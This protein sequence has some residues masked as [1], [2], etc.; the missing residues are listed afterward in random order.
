M[1]IAIPCADGEIDP[2]FGHTETFKLYDLKDG[3]IVSDLTLP[4]FGSGHQAMAEFLRAARA[5]VLI[6]GGIGAEAQRILTAQGVAIYPGFGGS[7]DDAARAFAI[8]ALQ[9]GAGGPCAGC[10]ENCGEG[11]CPHHSDSGC[12]CCR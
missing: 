11:G 12:G 6:C 3:E 2:H 5:D 7:A 4:T 8:G 1:R 10:S 9:K